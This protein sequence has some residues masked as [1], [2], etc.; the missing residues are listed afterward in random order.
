MKSY[1]AYHVIT[2]EWNEKSITEGNSQHQRGK[3]TDM[4][5][6]LTCGSMEK[7]EMK[8]ENT[9]DKLILKFYGNEGTPTS[10]N[11]LGKRRT[12]LEDSSRLDFKNCYKATVIKTMWYWHRGRHT[13][14]WNIIQRPKINQYI[15]GQ[16]IV[17]KGAKTTKE[18]I[19]SLCNRCCWDNWISTCKRMKLYSFL[20][21]CK[22]INSKRAKYL[23]IRAETIKFLEGNIS[24]N[25]CDLGLD[26]CFFFQ[27]DTK[28][29]SNKRKNR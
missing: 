20:I 18:R 13:N 24:I 17:D 29:T 27:Y 28:N 9:W 2:I 10:Q 8:L 21:S 22:K 7:S 6:L 14:Q 3:F 25:F 23:N 1:K 5:K 4:W 11:D 12:M 19:S 16:L 15:C 26:K